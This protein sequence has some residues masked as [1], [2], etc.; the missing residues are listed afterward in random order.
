MILKI[1]YV[2]PA[3]QHATKNICTRGNARV[4]LLVVNKEASHFP[5]C[6]Q[7]GE[8]FNLFMVASIQSIYD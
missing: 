1:N 3:A 6:T 8:V 2:K 7:K 5:I 4:F